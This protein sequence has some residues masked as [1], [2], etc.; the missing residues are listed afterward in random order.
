MTGTEASRYRLRGEVGGVVRAYALR[1]GTTDIG[2]VTGNGVV[3][4]VRGVSRQH[5]RL[6]VS[7]EDLTLEDLG[8]RNG[9]LANGVRIQRT[10][11]Q[12]GDEVRIG[13]VI[14]TL[15]EI[16]A[17][18]TE[19][20]AIAR[21]T[22][23]TPVPGLSARD[24]TGVSA[25]DAAHIALGVV[26]AF[27]SRLSVRPLPD[28]AGAVAH[29]KRELG[30]R[31]A[32]VFEMVRREP[33]VVAADGD[34]PELA[35]RDDLLDFARPAT[36]GPTGTITARTFAG[37]PPLCCA[38][39][40]GPAGDRLG[41]AVWGELRT[42]R[43]ETERLLRILLGLADRFRTRTLHQAA[44]VAA[45]GLAFPEGYVRGGSPGMASVYAQ[46][47]S[48][49]QGDM[50]VLILGETGVGKEH[51]ARSLHASSPRR[52]R[53]FVA[54]NCAAI[55]ADLLEA[56]MFGIGKGIAT[57]V[58]ER[59]GKFQLATGGTLF[60][61]EIG[62]MP[63]AL[64]AK[65][66]R[67]LQE[68]EVQPVGGAPVAVDIRVVSATNS[69][70]QRRMEE[71]LFRRDLYYR[72]AGFALMVPPLRERKEDVPALVEDFLGTFSREAGKSVRGITV[73]TLRTLTEYAWP[74]NVRE[75]Q[76]E[77]RRLVYLCPPGEAI[78]SSMLS[79]HILA[80]PRDADGQPPASLQL[81]ANV[82]RLERR[83]IREA[84][85]R[86]GGN[87]S[88]AARLLGLSR[89]G[90]ANKMQRLGITD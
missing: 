23:P 61:D 59:A 46:M 20:A 80:A 11:L 60:L 42:G 39:V 56:E 73:K 85:A 27:L 14:L 31:G 64:Q 76:H 33:V 32:G 62:D 78:E 88:Q 44:G 13:P 51:L 74:G 6:V 53:P 57:G 17:A 54:L 70:L 15:E 36:G 48:L 2:S 19:L 38:I 41:L 1:Q 67:A 52:N 45:P 10:R 63:L 50:P 55:P 8:S 77:V 79:E 84:L 90:L 43:D 28:L 87:R 71:G 3:L 9:T 35:G 49:L 34:L 16:D 47:Q 4:P 72:V 37:D 86:A 26:E 25:G 5:A 29:L 7:A 69:D 18:D 22:G 89:N 58:V 82:D 40:S 66:L 83:L 81:D 30:A 68:K 75:L 65:L 12:P 24:T 21:G